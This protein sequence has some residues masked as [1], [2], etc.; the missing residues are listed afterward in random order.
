MPDLLEGQ[1]AIDDFVFGSASDEVVVLSGGGWDQ[2]SVD[3]RDQDQ[4]APLGD[5]LF[6]GRDRLTPPTWKFSLACRRD[7]D[8]MG[9]VRSLARAWR[10]DN[11]RMVPGARQKLSY[12]QNGVQR[13]VYGRGRL[14]DPEPQD[15]TDHDFRVV[16][17]T[18]RL[19]DVLAY[20]TEHSVLLGL[21]STAIG[22]T[23]LVLPSV[24]P[25]ETLTSPQ[26]RRGIV[27]VATDTATPF[28]VRITGPIAGQATDFKLWSTGWTL[29]LKTELLPGQVIEI[30]TSTGRIT[31]NGAPFGLSAPGS[32]LRARLQYGAQELVF[33]ANDP[34]NTVTAEVTWRDVSV[35][36]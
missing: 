19:S 21:V 15:V 5:T 18:F 23:G 35:L 12:R 29:A 16:S 2:G 14:F 8:V 33:T 6:M 30:D 4:P 22:E 3:V 10:P 28:T 27:T 20:G 36:A 24:L 11:V 1:F 26:E 9:L 7:G 17:C 34:T 32:N 25:W 13:F 31:R